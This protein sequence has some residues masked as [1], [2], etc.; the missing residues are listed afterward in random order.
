MLADQLKKEPGFLV[1]FLRGKATA[2]EITER[3]GEPGDEMDSTNPAVVSQLLSTASQEELK[4]ALAYASEKVPTMDSETGEE[5]MDRRLGDIADMI[6]PKIKGGRK[7]RRRVSRKVK[8]SRRLQKK[9][10]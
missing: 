2:Q 7:T 1:R 10:K 5:V 9:R 8:K 6:Q 4:E 3:G